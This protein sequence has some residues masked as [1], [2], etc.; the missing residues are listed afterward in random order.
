MVRAINKI[1][2]DHSTPFADFAIGTSKS[3]EIVG[4]ICSRVPLVCVGT[5]LHMNPT[6]SALVADFERYEIQGRRPSA[7]CVVAPFVRQ[8]YRAI[9]LFSY[10]V[11]MDCHPENSL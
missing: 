8:P 3:S 2:E 6:A 10:P 7:C 11:S 9:L 1:I 5:L 4:V